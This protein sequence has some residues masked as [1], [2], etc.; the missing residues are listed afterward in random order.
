MSREATTASLVRLV[1]PSRFRGRLRSAAWSAGYYARGP[2]RHD[3]APAGACKPSGR[4]ICYPL[5]LRGL[6]SC[7][8]SSTVIRAMVFHPNRSSEK[9]LAV[10]PRA[11]H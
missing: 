8:Y 3:P 11:R 5:G 6:H 2:T 4:L 9:R 1:D 10:S 7:A